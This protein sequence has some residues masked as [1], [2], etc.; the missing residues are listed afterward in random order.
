MVVC[1]HHHHHVG[2]DGF[3]VEDYDCNGNIGDDDDDLG[4]QGYQN[5]YGFCR[6]F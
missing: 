4:V 2:D 3:L 5:K 6:R 1:G